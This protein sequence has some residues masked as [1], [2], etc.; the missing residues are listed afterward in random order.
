M[1]IVAFAYDLYTL[2]EDYGIKRAAI[3]IRC[4]GATPPQE[5]LW[6]KLVPSKRDPLASLAGPLT[7]VIALGVAAAG[8]F[9]P[10]SNSVVYSGWLALSASLIVGLRY[11]KNRLVAK[12]ESWENEILDCQ[13]GLNAQIPDLG[14]EEQGRP[15]ST[16]LPQSGDLQRPGQAPLRGSE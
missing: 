11:F 5:K 12:L 1:P 2:G 6:E 7:S 4:S 10:E 15:S 14:I 9:P 13:K 8:L 3:F 16:E